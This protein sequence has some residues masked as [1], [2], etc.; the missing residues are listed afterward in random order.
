MFTKKQRQIL[1]KAVSDGGVTQKELEDVYK[2]RS[3]IS[4]VLGK[5]VDRG[6]LEEEE[7]PDC[8]NAQKLY[9]PTEKTQAVVQ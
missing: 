7:A 2:H 1:E 4:D 8:D 5:M 9:S 6:Y 3:N